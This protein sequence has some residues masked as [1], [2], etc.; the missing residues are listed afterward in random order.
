MNDYGKRILLVEDDH[1]IRR[2]L[3]DLFTQEGY[4]VYE[5]ADGTQAVVEMDKRHYDAVLSDYHMPRMDGLAF[6]DIS[7]H[8]WPE[9][10]IILSSCDPE[11]TDSENP[12]F[13][14]A[15]ARLGKP[16]D[17][18]QLLDTVYRA[19]HGISDR[20]LQETG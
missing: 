18:H 14:R 5:A 6:L 11:L 4:Q 7:T 8:L 10:P 20:Y 13:R 15:F 19:T 12:M 1:D 17:L 16:F 3:G 9:T 2:L